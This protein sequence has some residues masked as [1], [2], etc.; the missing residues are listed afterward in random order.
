MTYDKRQPWST[1]IHLPLFIRGPGI[2][3]GSA[4]PDL[5]SMPDLSAT[6]LDMAGVAGPPHF[7]GHSI[8]PALTRQRGAA[9]ANAEID[10]AA[11]AGTASADIAADADAAATAAAAAAA[12]A[13]AAGATAGAIAAA[14]RL[15]VLVE[16]HGETLN[17]GA[18]SAAC[19]ATHGTD[20]WCTSDGREIPTP[21]FFSGEELCL[22][23]DS[24]NN[25]FACLR[26]LTA[27]ASYR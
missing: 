7:D 19:A 14:P 21:P 18:A 9:A 6:L 3:A 26:A 25:T 5:V 13:T 23:I 22:C 24:A 8:L 4:L 2:Q 15:M 16:Y 17:G 11:A 1:D 20:L 10:G 12:G 27:A